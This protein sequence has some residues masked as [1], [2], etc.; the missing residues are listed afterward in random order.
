MFEAWEASGAVAGRRHKVWYSSPYFYLWRPGQALLRTLGGQGC[1]AERCVKAAYNTSAMRV[2]STTLS[3]SIYHGLHWLSISYIFDVKEMQLL[4]DKVGEATTVADHRQTT[5]DT[6]ATPAL[7]VRFELSCH[8]PLYDLSTSMY[9]KTYRFPHMASKSSA[10]ARSQQ[11][12]LDSISDTDPSG[13]N[14]TPPSQ[15]YHA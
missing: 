6:Y 2:H 13:S 11:R 15:V 5:I 10:T 9:P 14:S 3:I 12:Q 7:F 1:L 4:S 8:V